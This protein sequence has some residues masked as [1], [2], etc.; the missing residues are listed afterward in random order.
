MKIGLIDV[1]GTNFPNLPLMKI[2]AWHKERGYQVEWYDQLTSGHMDRVYMSKVFNFTPDYQ[3][4][5]YA[6]EIIKGGSGYCIETKD[7]RECFHEERDTWL[8]HEI[9]HIYPDY[10]LYPELTKDTAYGFMSRGCPNGCVFCHVGAKEGRKSYKV[11]DLSEFWRG[12][13]N[14]VLLDPNP[15]ACPEWRDNLQQLID[16][17]ANVDFC[18]GVDIRIMTPEMAEM[19]LKIKVKT[20][21]FAWDRYPDKSIVVPKLEMFKKLSGWGRDKISVYILVN[22]NTTTEQDIERVQTCR[23]LGIQPYPMVYNKGEFFYRN[24]RLRPR[25]ELLKK[26]TQEQ[27]D[28]A[29]ISRD[30]QRWCNPRVFWQCERF[31]DYKPGRIQRLEG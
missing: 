29:V 16:S 27:I 30:I 17:G 1:D 18:Q 22:F 4:P 25:G 23:R 13:K 20:I 9:E 28:H 5:I 10:S 7:G 21:H 12:Q 8:L 11:A 26:Y 19:I 31:E 2:S 3:Y 14:I 24:G 15:T 6:D